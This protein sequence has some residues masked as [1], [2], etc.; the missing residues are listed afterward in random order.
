MPLQDEPQTDCKTN[1]ASGQTLT[2]HRNT[3][4]QMPLQNKHRQTTERL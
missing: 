1:T 2:N 3:V 4:K